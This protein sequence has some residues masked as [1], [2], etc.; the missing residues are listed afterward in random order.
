MV[1]APLALYCGFLAWA[2]GGVRSRAVSGPVDLFFL[3]FG[4]SGLFFVGPAHALVPIDALIDKGGLA[5]VLMMLLYFLFALLLGLTRRFRLTVYNISL[6]GVRRRLHEYT[7]RYS[8]AMETAGDVFHF[9]ANGVTLFLEAFPAMKTVTATVLGRSPKSLD[10]AIFEKDLTVILGGVAD[11]VSPLRK[12]CVVLFLTLAFGTMA[13][14]V[15]DSG[16]W[17]RGFLFYLFS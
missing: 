7:D 10:G 4:L 9:P 5:W 8:I 1:L 17:T 11:G 6:E 14:A 16:E 3:F 13:T 2:H 12:Y 15:C